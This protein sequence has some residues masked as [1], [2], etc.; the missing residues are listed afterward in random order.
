MPSNQCYISIIVVP[1]PPSH[2]I[3]FMLYAA[4][5]NLHQVTNR[6]TTMHRFGTQSAAI[7]D[8]L[9]ICDYHITENAGEHR[10]VEQA[11]YMGS[12]FHGFSGHGPLISTTYLLL[13]ID[14]FIGTDI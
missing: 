7:C 11:T 6:T 9:K 1:R 14:K 8:F 2:S 4:I 5:T 3:A 12:E 13:Y 10:S